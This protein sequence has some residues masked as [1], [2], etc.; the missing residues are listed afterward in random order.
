LFQILFWYLAVLGT[1]PGP[2][3]SLSI[4]GEIF[5]NNRGIIM[6]RPIFGAGTEFVLAVFLLA[7]LASLGL[8]VWAIRR[9]NR[10]GE[11]FPLLWTALGMMIGAPLIVLL[12]LGFPIGFEQPQFRGFNF[13]G[14]VRL[15]PEFVALLIALTTYT[16]AFIAEVVRAGI[17][18]VS[19][20]QTEAALALGLRRGLTLR[21]V[22]VPQALRVIV[23]PLTN[24]YLNLTKNSSLA[25]AIG[26][27]DLFA[28][29]AG[30]TLNQT[31]QA[32]EI[33]AI[34]MAVY[35]VISLVTS[36]LMNWYNAH[37]RVAER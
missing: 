7:V 19:R 31:G 29:F 13:V 27:P 34:T 12:V 36:G 2:R 9:Q 18:A 20:G 11:Q 15:L 4:F 33:I 24:Q 37:I 35:L 5:I 16:A 25:V 21:L 32:I 22:V 30:T 28:V 3:Q 26:Y 6:P 17:L 23:P 8:R 14:G 1:L 10:T